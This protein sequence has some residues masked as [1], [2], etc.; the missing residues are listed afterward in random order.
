MMKE[1]KDLV[2]QMPEDMRGHKKSDAL[3]KAFLKLSSES[4]RV[5]LGGKEV[6]RV[7]LDIL[8]N[9]V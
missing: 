2:S 3:K 4:E 5:S 6:D 9:P 8:S 1:R 7:V